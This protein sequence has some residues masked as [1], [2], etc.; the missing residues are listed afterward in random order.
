[1]KI[2]WWSINFLSNYKVLNEISGGLLIV[3]C[4]GKIMIIFDVME[5][6]LT[7]FVFTII[8]K[9]IVMEIVFVETVTKT[10]TEKTDRCD[11]VFREKCKEIWEKT[12]LW[13]VPCYKIVECEIWKIITVSIFIIVSASTTHRLRD[14]LSLKR[15]NRG[16]NN[17]FQ[18]FTRS[19]LFSNDALNGKPG[20]ILTAKLCGYKWLTLDNRQRGKMSSLRSQAWS[21]LVQFFVAADWGMC[22]IAVEFTR[23]VMQIFSVRRIPAPV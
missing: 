7:N 22:W 8:R 19:F 9:T 15:L 4:L 3:W 16:A 23:P 10:W 21:L 1:M 14:I 2:S 18:L 11:R 20:N 13:N 12:M 6:C 5:A 17:N